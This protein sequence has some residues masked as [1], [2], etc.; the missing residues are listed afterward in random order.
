MLEKED[1]LVAELDELRQ[2]HHRMKEEFERQL[3]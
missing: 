2:E 3:E 1:E